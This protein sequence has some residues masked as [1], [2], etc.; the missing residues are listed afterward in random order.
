VCVVFFY[1]TNILFHL[2]EG[3]FPSPFSQ[4]TR[5]P[6]KRAP[7]LTVGGIPTT[8][9]VA[10]FRSVIL[11]LEGLDVVVHPSSTADPEDA[12]HIAA[13]IRITQYLDSPLSES[14]KML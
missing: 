1:P 8:I 6:S 3:L 10:L 12:R 7:G 11:V 9:P 4:H 13:H 2:E 5:L 14:Y